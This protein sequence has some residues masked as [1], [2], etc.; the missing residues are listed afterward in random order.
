MSGKVRSRHR[1]AKP[2]GKQPLPP[3]VGLLFKKGWIEEHLDEATPQMLAEA[4]AFIEA[5]E[6]E[7]AQ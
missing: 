3:V 4:V 7:E 2:G 6:R 5:Q 1:A